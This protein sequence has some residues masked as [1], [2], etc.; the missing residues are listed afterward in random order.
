[1]NPK[2]NAPVQ[3]KDGVIIYDPSDDQFDDELDF[4]SSTRDVSTYTN[5]EQHEIWDEVDGVWFK[6]WLPKG[7][8]GPT[9][10]QIEKEA[11]AWP[12]TVGVVASVVVFISMAICLSCWLYL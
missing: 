7:S 12:V 9:D 1:M 10:E 4:E 11:N 6:A 2:R 5:F 3:D 8:V